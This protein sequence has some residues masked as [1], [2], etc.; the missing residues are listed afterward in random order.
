MKSVK[1]ARHIK[2]RNE[3]RVENESEYEHNKRECEKIEQSK[4]KRTK[5]GDNVSINESIA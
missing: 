3:V 2:D 4:R 1:L 5:T